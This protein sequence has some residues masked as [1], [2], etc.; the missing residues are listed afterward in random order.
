MAYTAYAT[1]SDYASYMMVE[2]S[3]LSANVPRLLQRASEL[4][5][6]A[7]RDNI[8]ESNESHLEALQ[9]AT[10]AQVEYWENASEGSAIMIGVKSFSIGN[11]QMDYGGSGKDS[12]GIQQISSRTKNY[13]NKERLLY[14]GVRMANV[15]NSDLSNG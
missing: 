9:L 1:I 4:V 3:E 13:L 11:F 14:R 2:E 7:C 8:D 10:C 5:N 12:G 15:D 6:Q